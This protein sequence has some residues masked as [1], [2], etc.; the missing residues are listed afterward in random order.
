MRQTTPVEVRFWRRVEKG[1]GCWPWLGAVSRYGYGI[2]ASAPGRAG[3]AHRIAWELTHGAIPEGLFVCHHCDNR[4]CVRPDHL[5]LGTPADNMRDMARKG[6]GPSG[7]NSGSA[8]LTDN[9]VLEARRLRAEQ[10]MPFK[11]L[12]ALYGVNSKTMRRAVY[13]HSWSHLPGAAPR[14]IN[15]RERE[16]LAVIALALQSARNNG[17]ETALALDGAWVVVRPLHKKE[18]A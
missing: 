5:F 6:R 3:R 16:N 7:E 18:H 1:D 11:D 13:G 4:I 12:A 9:D 10:G 8:M 2:F 15:A 14:P 17:M